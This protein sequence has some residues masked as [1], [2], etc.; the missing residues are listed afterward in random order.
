MG[1][2]K[3]KR[4]GR[5]ESMIDGKVRRGGTGARGGREHRKG[6]EGGISSTVSRGLLK[7]KYNTFSTTDKSGCTLSQSLTQRSIWKWI[8]ARFV[9]GCAS[10]S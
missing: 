7:F 5:G 6:R 9:Q 2:V 1:K 3:R 10:P 8:R 4:K